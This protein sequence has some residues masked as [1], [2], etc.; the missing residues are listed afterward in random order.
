[1]LA[2]PLREQDA[3]HQ[4]ESSL[5]QL[6]LVM[7]VLARD[8]WG[9]PAARDND[10]LRDLNLAIP[11]AEFV[12]H[13]SSQA[14]AE[15]VGEPRRNTTTALHPSPPRDRDVSFGDPGIGRALSGEK[16]YNGEP[17]RVAPWSPPNVVMSCHPASWQA[18]SKKDEVLHKTDDEL[19]RISLEVLDSWSGVFLRTH[20]IPLAK[21]LAAMQRL[22]QDGVATMSEGRKPALEFTSVGALPPVDESLLRNHRQDLLS[23]FKNDAHR[24][25]TYLKVIKCRRF[26]D[27]SKP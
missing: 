14:Y 13:L 21:Q 17:P 22:L 24:V 20:A 18:P 19:L 3:F 2:I 7:S 5:A 25:V 9:R 12:Y 15:L 4:L 27:C 10:P 23:C 11:I 16:P 8:A 1:M 26:H 6:L